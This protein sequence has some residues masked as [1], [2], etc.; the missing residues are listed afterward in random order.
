M[1]LGTPCLSMY[2]PVVYGSIRSDGILKE[3]FQFVVRR[4]NI[5]IERLSIFPTAPLVCAIEVPLHYNTDVF[6][7]VY[8]MLRCGP[9]LGLSFRIC[10]RELV[11]IYDSR[12]GLCLGN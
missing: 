6:L 8:P 10:G 4:S 11:D 1:P 12:W 2:A 7:F 3:V 9:H 5:F